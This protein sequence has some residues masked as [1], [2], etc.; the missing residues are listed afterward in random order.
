M[1]C[2]LRNWQRHLF[3]QIQL[4]VSTSVRIGLNCNFPTLMVYYSILARVD[5]SIEFRYCNRMPFNAIGFICES[6]EIK[7][8]TE[9]STIFSYCD[10]Y[11]IIIFNAHFSNCYIHNLHTQYMILFHIHVCAFQS[12]MRLSSD[13]LSLRV[14]PQHSA[15]IDSLGSIYDTFMCT[16]PIQRNTIIST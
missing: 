9:R 2:S 11:V 5:N 4:N 1:W 13:K 7:S 12:L 15:P 6:T 10:L 16:L 8:T 3:V 14:I